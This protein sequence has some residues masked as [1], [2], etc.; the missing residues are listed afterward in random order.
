MAFTQYRLKLS[1][2]YGRDLSFIDPSKTKKLSYATLVAENDSI[3]Q[4]TSYDLRDVGHQ[5]SRLKI[6]FKAK[7]CLK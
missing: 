3:G 5:I 4:I 6:V 2:L 7:L 1:T